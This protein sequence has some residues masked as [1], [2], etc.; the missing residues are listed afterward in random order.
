MI[1]KIT[2]TD[3]TNSK[4]QRKI[5]GILE[6]SQNSKKLKKKFLIAHNSLNIADPCT[7]TCGL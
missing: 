5:L 2:Q 6:E 4:S 1:Q 3:Q 7:V